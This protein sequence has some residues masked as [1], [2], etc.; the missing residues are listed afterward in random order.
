MKRFFTGTALIA[1]LAGLMLYGYGCGGGAGI[2]SV[3]TSTGT[4]SASTSSF[5]NET[6]DDVTAYAAASIGTDATTVT[7][8]ADGTSPTAATYEDMSTCATCHQEKYD[9]FLETNHN[10]AWNKKAV[11]LRQDYSNKSLFQYYKESTPSKTYCVNCHTVNMPF[12]DADGDSAYDAGETVA[13]GMDATRPS[14]ADYSVVPT[15]FQGIQCENCHGPASLHVAGDQGKIAGHLEANRSST[16]QYCHTQYEEW[17]KSKHSVAASSDATITTGGVSHPL[18]GYNY[19]KTSGNCGGCHTGD[20]FQ[21]AI[22]DNQEPK[23]YCGT[24]YTGTNKTADCVA[25][26]A[27]EETGNGHFGITCTTCHDPHALAKGE[28]QLRVSRE[29][30]CMKCHNARYRKYYSSGETKYDKTP[31]G[32]RGVHLAAQKEMWSGGS[33]GNGAVQPATG[34]PVANSYGYTN[35]KTNLFVKYSFINTGTAMGST[36]CVDCHMYSYTNRSAGIEWLGHTFKPQTQACESCHSSMNA[37][38]VIAAKQTRFLEKEEDLDARFTNLLTGLGAVGTSS[39]CPE[40]SPDRM[41]CNAIATGSATRDTC[42][43][44]EYNIR[45]METDQ[46][47]GVHNEAYVNA[48]YEATDAMLKSLGY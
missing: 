31:G 14:Y 36:T 47:E 8:F 4:G 1:A 21:R 7:T 43:L 41:C 42:S 40:D 15:E 46:S 44:I 26:V 28:S 24:G 11:Q 5:V 25:F 39:T 20:G 29:D 38:S 10:I 27:G 45:F 35:D 48:V 17:T 22:R 6:P 32:G 34:T 37:A 16:C 13:F 19:A 2:N 9:S 18:G 30:I 33:L 12:V 23:D 3:V